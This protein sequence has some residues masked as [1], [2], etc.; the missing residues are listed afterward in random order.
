VVNDRGIRQIY[1]P[2]MWKI[3]VPPRLHIFPWFLANDKIL[4]KNNLA[5]RRHVDDGSCLFCTDLEF[6]SHLMFECCV[7]KNIWLV[8]SELFEKR[9]GTDFESV[10]KWWL[11]DKT[12]QSF[13]HI[14]TTAIM[15]SLWK[16]RNEICFQVVKWMGMHVLFFKCAKMMRR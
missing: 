4:T 16:L 5:K 7:A 15:W 14:C 10:A 1:T 3:V 9:I 8:C 6:A 13:E 2:V 12:I 11:C